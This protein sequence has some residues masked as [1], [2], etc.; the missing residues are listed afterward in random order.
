MSVNYFV[1]IVTLSKYN[2]KWERNGEKIPL[3]KD[4]FDF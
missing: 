3:F 2:K 1:D 4:A